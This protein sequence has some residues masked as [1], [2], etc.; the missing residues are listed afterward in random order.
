MEVIYDLAERYDL[1]KYQP[2]F[3][4]IS[5]TIGNVKVTDFQDG[6]S[7]SPI[8]LNYE[9]QIS[10]G[11][12]ETGNQFSIELYDDTAIEIEYLLY[13]NLINFTVN[14]SEL[15]DVLEEDSEVSD[16]DLNDDSELDDTTTG[17]S[18]EDSGDNEESK[19]KRTTAR[20][21]V[22]AVSLSNKEN[23]DD[24]DSEDNK[25][26]EDS[27]DDELEE[28]DGDEEAETDMSDASLNNPDT[29]LII[30]YGWADKYGKAIVSNNIYGVFTEYNISFND[31]STILTINGVSS[32][33]VDTSKV[34]TMEF[35][36][37]L[38]LGSPST[39]VRYLCEQEGIPI[40][41]IEETE[42][43]YDENGN[44][45]TF[46][47]NNETTMHFIKTQLEEISKSKETGVVGYDCFIG[48]DNKL[49]F[50]S[51]TVAKNLSISVTTESST[52]TNKT[53]KSKKSTTSSKNDSKAKSSVLYA[54]SSS[55]SGKYGTVFIGDS[56]TVGM[57][58][59]VHGGSVG[60]SVE[61]QEGDEYWS[62]V[63]GGTLSNVKSSW[64]N[65]KSKVD[66]NNT[67]LVILSGVNDIGNISGYESFL[68]DVVNNSCYNVYFVSVNPIDEDKYLSGYVSNAK[69]Q[70]FN[71]EMKS[72]ASK[73]G[74]HFID[75]YSTVLKEINSS[76]SATDSQ[77]LHY[78]SSVYQKIYNKV[79]NSVGSGGSG[80][81]NDGGSVAESSLP[82]SKITVT[83]YYEYYSGRINNQVISF[84]PDWTS[85][86][87]N[88]A[89]LMS[90]VASVDEVRNQIINLTIDKS[91]NSDMYI[92]DFINEKKSLI[93]GKSSADM[94]TLANNALSLWN[95]NYRMTNDAT[96]EIMGDPNVRVKEWIYLS[97]YTK[98]GFL[99]HTSGI[100]FVEEATDTISD[101]SYITT[102]SLKKNAWEGFGNE[103]SNS[104]G[105][106]TSGM[107]DIYNGQY[108]LAWPLPAA[109]GITAYTYSGHTHHARDFQPPTALWG[110]PVVAILDGTVKAAGLGVEDA[111]YGNSV[112]IEHNDGWKS[113]YAHL[114]YVSVKA[115]DKVKKGQILG[116]CGSTGNSSGL[117]LHM[118][119][120]SPWG[121]V[122]PG[123][124]YPDYCTLT[125]S[126]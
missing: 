62:A 63:V 3:P 90:D 87:T 77:G 83:A 72:F 67:N 115:G 82:P 49:Y 19:T 103:G 113:R 80:S 51:A 41:M 66:K 100:Y 52:N 79:S 58:Q 22:K 114:D 97:V 8:S 9:R 112:Y 81:S 42:S 96:L 50:V 16:V 118:E 29:N 10:V 34:D 64:K 39:I 102:L 74:I 27:E 40:G 101:G 60:N 93:L 23:E 73:N 21:S 123:P 119:V 126:E 107:G 38:F 24:E 28:S 122:D 6:I 13:S 92:M 46:T 45:R 43:L 76:N 110:T 99:H 117:H 1:T 12:Q 120:C 104:G 54:K 59:A 17:D 18:D 70:Q 56:R 88:S 37:D 47:R 35:P 57:Y 108:G 95:Y 106:A 36:G 91:E 105:S 65:I 61:A 55:S 109:M 124:F 2:L 68:E 31:T 71:K 84:S 121:W 89:T 33:V 53:D 98:F 86:V 116:G 75:T 30:E 111:S 26:D 32:S 7:D 5:V 11:S 20:R 14:D 15:L 125:G 25:D 48:E 94:Q 69:I 85:K 78:S 44:Y 4:F